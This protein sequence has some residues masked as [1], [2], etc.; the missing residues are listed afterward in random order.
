M[1]VISERVKEK[2]EY[3]EIKG[4]EYP[5]QNSRCDGE[6]PSRSACVTV[7]VRWN[8]ECHWVPNP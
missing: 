7:S 6:L 3:E 8:C 4:I 2:D 5:A 1:K